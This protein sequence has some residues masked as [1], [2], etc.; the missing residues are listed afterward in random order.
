MSNWEE[1][2]VKLQI[3][4]QDEADRDR[5]RALAAF[6]KA[7]IAERAPVAEEREE[8]LLAG[9]QR[10]L[11]EFE[12]RIEHP[13]RDDAGSFFSGQMQALGWSLRCVAFAAFSMHP[14]FRQDFRP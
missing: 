3:A 6:I 5:D 14:D 4:I 13:H 10:G 9:V 1:A 2:A 12:E 8:R 11:L 7:R